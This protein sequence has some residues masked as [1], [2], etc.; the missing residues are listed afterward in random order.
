MAKKLIFLNLCVFLFLS[1]WCFKCIL[2]RFWKSHILKWFFTRGIMKKDFNKNIQNKCR[3]HQ[4]CT[5]QNLKKTHFCWRKW[6]KWIRW[7]SKQ[8]SVNQLIVSALKKENTKKADGKSLSPLC[9][10]QSQ[11]QDVHLLFWMLGHTIWKVIHSIIHYNFPDPVPP[12]KPASLRCVCV[13]PLVMYLFF[14]QIK[15]LNQ[16]LII[17]DQGTIKKSFEVEL[18]LKWLT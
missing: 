6:L 3:P 11:V 10:D 2:Q 9:Y 13:C 16:R 4:I 12:M 8:L 7:I 5:R 15:A 14:A 18:S 17:I 1:L